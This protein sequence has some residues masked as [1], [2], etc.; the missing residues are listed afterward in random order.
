MNNE[1]ICEKIVINS[2][3][4]RFTITV[5]SF[6]ILYKISDDNY[7][8]KHLYLILPILLHLFDILDTRIY[9]TRCCDHWIYQKLDKIT[10]ILSYI[11]LIFMIKDDKL[12]HLFILYRL[13]GV[14]FFTQT[15]NSYYLVI[16]FDFIK[17]YLIYKYFFGNNYSYIYIFIILKIIFEYL[18]HIVHNN[19]NKK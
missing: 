12:L 6:I 3:I 18:L 1:I 19:Y 2:M 5:I 16:F 15:K 7:I 11:L 9:S 10:D 17:E 13:L 14:I 8:R 4:L